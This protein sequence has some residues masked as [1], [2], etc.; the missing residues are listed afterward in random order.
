MLCYCEYHNGINCLFLISADPLWVVRRVRLVFV[1]SAPP[2]VLPMG[3][4]F[5]RFGGGPPPPYRTGRFPESVKNQER[6]RKGSQEGLGVPMRPPLVPKTSIPLERGIEITKLTEQSECCEKRPRRSQIGHQN[7]PKIDQTVCPPLALA[8]PGG[9]KRDPWRTQRSQE[10]PRA[11]KV[12]KRRSQ[13]DPKWWHNDVLGRRKCNFRRSR[14]PKG[15][16]SRKIVSANWRA[17]CPFCTLTFRCAPAALGDLLPLGTRG[18]RHGRQP[19]NKNLP[20]GTK[21]A[22]IP[23]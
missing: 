8:L 11:P 5:P 23:G 9:P 22:R 18:R 15:K 3:V 13:K 6:G 17:S 2:V 1:S 20:V 14:P 21:V 4:R 7:D 16:T 12:A 10:S 19:L